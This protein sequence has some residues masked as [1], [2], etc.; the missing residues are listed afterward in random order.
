MLYLERV[1]S[2][3]SESPI[4]EERLNRGRERLQ[5]MLRE[6]NLYHVQFLLG[7][8]LIFMHFELCLFY[9]NRTVNSRGAFP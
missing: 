5:A 2:L 3:L 1:L 9:L 4:N 8:T 6:S 7:E